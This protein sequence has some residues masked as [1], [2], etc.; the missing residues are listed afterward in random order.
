MGNLAVL[1]RGQSFKGSGADI[2]SLGCDISF[3]FGCWGGQDFCPLCWAHFQ[4]GM[5]VVETPFHLLVSLRAF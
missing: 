2:S 5:L 3:A 4:C 1:H